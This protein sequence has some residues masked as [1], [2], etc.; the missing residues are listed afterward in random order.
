MVPDRKRAG[1][2]AMSRRAFLQASGGV[3]GGAW[4]AMHAPAVLA[5]AQAAL[6]ARQAAEPFRNLSPA[7]G[8]GLEA[9]ASRIVPTDDSPGAREAGVIYFID[10]A[11]GGFMA[12]SSGVLLEGMA[13]LDAVAF[14]R[15]GEPFSKLG[16]AAQ[17]DLLRGIEETPFFGLVQ[18]L[19][20]AGMFALPEYGGNR[21]HLG[22]ALLGFDHRHAWA[23]PFGHYDAELNDHPAPRA[24]D[25]EG[26]GHG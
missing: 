3:A 12:E 9:V 17:D 18:F 19:T 23:P 11:L 25:D 13:A 6:R 2:A 15:H 7:G 22:W 14:E 24:G 20:V 26:H 8:E 5:A 4:L 10:Q 16:P 1:P 21:D